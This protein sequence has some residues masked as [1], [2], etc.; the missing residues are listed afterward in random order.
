MPTVAPVVATI[1][2]SQKRT[3]GRSR[4]RLSSASRSQRGGPFARSRAPGSTDRWAIVLS[5]HQCSG[6]VDR[7]VGCRVARLAED[8]IDRGVADRRGRPFL[9]WL[10]CVLVQ[11]TEGP[12]ADKVTLVKPWNDQKLAL[13]WT[14]R[15]G[16]G[17]RARAHGG[18]QR[19]S[20][21]VST[22]STTTC[23]PSPQHSARIARIA[24]QARQLRKPRLRSALSRSRPMNTR[25]LARRSSAAQGRSSAMFTSECTPWT[26]ARRSLPAIF[27]MP[28]IR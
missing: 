5:D 1:R 6:R 26:T 22:R 18:R 23:G 24:R 14:T 16:G 15:T 11:Q 20:T 13:A 17:A 10:L 2:A 3:N 4:K 9:A 25:W 8:P 21:R 28:L 19:G 12:A 27:R 7:P